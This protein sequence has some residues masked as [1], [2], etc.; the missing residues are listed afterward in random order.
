M[1]QNQT[2][3]MVSWLDEE[4]RKDKALIMKLE[5][6]AA[7]QTAIIEEMNRRMKG[8][9]AEMASLRAS[10]PAA[11]SFSDAITRL[12]TEVFANIEQAEER[13]LTAQ[14][15][16]K[17]MRD[18]DR[19]MLARAVE[20]LR[21]EVSTRLQREMQPRRTEEER[22]SRVAAELQ[23]YAD[24]LS[25]G[26]EDFERS[27]AFLEE[28]RRQDSKRI[29]DLSSQVLDMSK[30]QE[31]Q[32]TKIELLE[33][34]SRRNERV[35]DETIGTIK[36]LRQERQA[37]IEQE[38]LASQRREQAITDVVKRMEQFEEQAEAHMQQLAKYG[39]T[40]RTMQKSV[41]DFERLANRVDRRLNELAEVQRISEDRFR[42]EYEQFLQDDQ[43]RWRQF[44][45]TNEEAW[46][47]NGKTIAELTERVEMLDMAAGNHAAHL[48][49]IHRVQ[50]STF[51]ELA[52]MLHTM[53]ETASD[54]SKDLPALDA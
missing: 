21:Q 11:N 18:Q 44:T 38:A 51:R 52:D 34:L 5:E 45:L 20:D 12:R 10:M 47:E 17:R 33:E 19:E 40:H 9:E 54:G 46:R 15:D 41:D 37:W 13:R 31:T 28:Q 53:W 43:K 42:Q 35:L 32:Q 3:Q 27:L 25:K 49:N 39:E 29:A 8:M 26:L 22:L 6:R 23:V 50:Q 48:K 16:L 1:E 2:M 7:A 30:R 24:N 36:E 14:Q 4:R